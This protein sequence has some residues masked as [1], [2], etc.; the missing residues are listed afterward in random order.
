VRGSV[1]V[2][3]SFACIG[4]GSAKGA[5]SKTR[6]FDAILIY[7]VQKRELFQVIVQ[8]QFREGRDVVVS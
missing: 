1:R 7:S 5:N 8:A 6:M 3:D 2:S 4:V